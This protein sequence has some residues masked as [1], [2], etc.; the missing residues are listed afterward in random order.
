MRMI[1][2][3]N[4]HSLAAAAFVRAIEEQENEVLKQARR[5]MQDFAHKLNEGRPDENRA[6]RRAAER[7][8][9]KRK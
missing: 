9:K 5:E 8:A 1:N 3:L 7:A 4:A 6:Q 2:E